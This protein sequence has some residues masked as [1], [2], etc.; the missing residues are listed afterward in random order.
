MACNTKTSQIV[1]EAMNVTFGLKNKT[2]VTPTAV[3]PESASFKFSSTT[4]KYYAYYDSGAAVDPAFAGYTGILVDV[5]AATTIAEVVI[6]TK[7][8]IEA[9][10]TDVLVTISDDT[11]TASIEVMLVGPILEQTVDVDTLFLIETEKVGF[12]GDLGATESIDLSFEVS[13]L[14][15]TASQSG[16]TLLDK[17]ITGIAC[18]MSTTLLETSAENWANIMGSGVGSNFTPSGGTELTGLGTASIN[19]SYFDIASELTLHPVRLPSTDRSRDITI[20]KCVAEP[21]SIT[22]DGAEKSGF[23]V[24]FSALLDNDVDAAINLFHFGDGI[25][26]KRK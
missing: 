6:A 20:P 21:A 19:R 15:I 9:A 17:F 3:V 13:T 24:N 2:C 26:D 16:E 22:F 23:E 5:S 18:S 10:A 11:L 4:V 7:T 8:A 12:G 14:D 25:Q 1:V